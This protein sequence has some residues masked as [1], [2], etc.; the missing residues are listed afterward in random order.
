MRRSAP[1]WSAPRGTYT[2]DLL[3]ATLLLAIGGGLPSPRTL[4]QFGRR[5]RVVGWHEGAASIS[6]LTGAVAVVVS[7][8]SVVWV[9][10]DGRLVREISPARE[11]D[12]TF[13]ERRHS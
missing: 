11:P 9:F 7:E 1:A 3:F 5:R 13:R 12:L 4:R 10:D 8:D 6:G 2:G